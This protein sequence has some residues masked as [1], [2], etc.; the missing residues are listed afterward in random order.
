MVH[1]GGPL[2]RLL[3]RCC[4]TSLLSQVA[5]WFTVAVAAVWFTVAMV[6]TLLRLPCGLVL[7]QLAIQELTAVNGVPEIPH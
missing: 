5:A 2:L 3:W 6:T 4:Q 7:L 1:Y